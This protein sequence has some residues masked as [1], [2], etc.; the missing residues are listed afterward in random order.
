MTQKLNIEAMKELGPTLDSGFREGILEF[1]KTLYPSLPKARYYIYPS[2]P[3]VRLLKGYVLQYA[4]NEYMRA[5]N[6]EI[7]M[8][9]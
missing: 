8:N 9:V 1:S 6:D 4:P 7:P 3:P 5:A 2:W